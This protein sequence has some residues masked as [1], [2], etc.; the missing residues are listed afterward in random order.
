[1]LKF[2]ALGG[3]L[4]ALAAPAS[5]QP[6][7]QQQ[8]LDDLRMQQQAAE[9]RAVDQ[10]NQLQALDARLRADQA[11]ADLSVQRSGV[12]IPALPYGDPTLA[13]KA[14]AS[15]PAYP[16]VPDAALADSNKRVQ[17]AARSR[18]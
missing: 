8:Q 12:R 7:V 4:A 13:P 14:S 1:M 3:L 11:V 17:D 6:A 9:R 16:S 15:A 18:R 2:L 5:A 10:A